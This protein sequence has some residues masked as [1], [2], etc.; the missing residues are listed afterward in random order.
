MR[1]SSDTL[2]H[3]LTFTE[4]LVLS[5]LHIHLSAWPQHVRQTY[6]KS[7]SLL[8]GTSLSRSCIFRVVRTQYGLPSIIVRNPHLAGG[9]Y[10]NGCTLPW[11]LSI[12]S[13]ASSK[14]HQRHSTQQRCHKVDLR[15]HPEHACAPFK[16]HRIPKLDLEPQQKCRL[17]HCANVHRPLSAASRCHQ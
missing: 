8:R 6:S 13:M 2:V 14:A 3:K 7:N 15:G 16:T 12:L 17:T 1:H 4:R 11:Y 10:S 9:F 5:V